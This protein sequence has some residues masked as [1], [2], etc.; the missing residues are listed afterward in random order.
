MYS[1]NLSWKPL[2]D[3]LN[4]MLSQELIVEVDA[5]NSRDK[6]ISKYFEITQKGE[7]AVRYFDRAK[8]LFTVDQSSFNPLQTV[9]GRWR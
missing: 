3:I 9:R 4:I 2:Q 1:A 7:N 6:R 8:G 5:S